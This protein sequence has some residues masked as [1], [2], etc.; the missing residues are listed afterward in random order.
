[1]VGRIPHAEYLIIY[2]L[3]E[4]GAFARGYL[5]ETMILRELQSSGILTQAHHPVMERFSPYDLYVLGLGYG[6]IK[7]MYSGNS[8]FGGCN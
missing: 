4:W 6:D 5:F 2:C 3:A 7:N 8:G 1:V